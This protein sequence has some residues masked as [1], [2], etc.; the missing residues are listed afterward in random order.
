MRAAN[1]RTWGIA[2]RMAESQQ[3]CPDRAAIKSMMDVMPVD[4]DQ[5][6]LRVKAS[7]YEATACANHCRHERRAL[8]GLDRP[9]LLAHRT[10]CLQRVPVVEQPQ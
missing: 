9:K 10:V 1:L 8:L 2:A 7:A 5:D 6:Q 4:C 3:Y